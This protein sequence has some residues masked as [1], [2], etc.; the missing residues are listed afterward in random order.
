MAKKTASPSGRSDSSESLLTFLLLALV[1]VS[2]VRAVQDAGWLAQPWVLAWVS[3]FALLTGFAFARL[4]APAEFLHLASLLVGALALAYEGASTLAKG[5]LADRVANIADRIFIWLRI[6]R[7]GGI[8][9]DNMLFLLFLAALAWFIGYIGAYAAFKHNNAWLHIVGAGVALVVTVSYAENVSG[10]FFLFTPAAV[11]LLVQLHASRR[12]RAWRRAG[13]EQQ[14]KSFRGRLLRQGLVSAVATVLFSV[15]APGVASGAEIATAWQVVNRPWMDMQAEFARLFGPVNAGSAVGASNYGPTLAL[16][17]SVALSDQRVLEVQASE[18][19]R[20]RGVIYDRYT[21]QGWLTQ[22]RGQVDVPANGTTL[23]PAS[24]DRARME[25]VQK[26]RVLRLKGDLLFGASLPRLVSVPVRADLENL[27]SGR[28]A[29]EDTT[30]TDLGSIRA[31]LGPYR[32]QEYQ[33]TSAV[34]VATAD[35]LRQAGGDYPRLLAQRY[36]ALPRNLPGDVR[37]LARSL[38][39]DKDTPYDKV[40]AV[41][42]YLRSLTYTL[43]PPE[44]PLGR[45]AVEFFLFQ[46]KEGYC[47]YFSSSMVVLLRSLGI[48]ARVVAGYLPGTWDDALQ[49]YTVRE[50]DS[51]SWPEVYFPGYGWI[52]FEPTASVPAVIHPDVA[53]AAGGEGDTSG[54]TNPSAEAVPFEDPGDGLGPDSG[55]TGGSFGLPTSADYA[56]LLS[57]FGVVIGVA[58]LFRLGLYGWDRHFQRLPAAEAAYARMSVIARFFGRGPRPYETPFEY[59]Q[60]LARNVPGGAGA[61][62]GIATAFVRH[63]FGGEGEQPGDR[64]RLASAW[65]S[66]RGQLPRGLLRRL[67]IRLTRR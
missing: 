29:A 44:P 55:S 32:G 15:W 49:A 28:G 47:D 41:E 60:S 17:S 46:S 40:L 25:L 36:T 7:E 66:L 67:A 11:L 8:G 19:R 4:R 23:E 42:S 12:E 35:Q 56:F 43:T 5:S 61:I 6:T 64:Q 34:S 54:G 57:L 9:T 51:H 53:Q 65:Q 30:Y 48:P 59:A 14:A 31:V 52:E 39:A 16:Q 2:A 26:V 3:F 18:A 20:L 50:S 38:T 33:V 13:I 22:D 58:A 24:N 10:Y 45:D 21:G 1:Q 27:S 62:Q 37:A 63:R